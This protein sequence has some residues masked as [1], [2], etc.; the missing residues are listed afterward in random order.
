VSD[1]VQCAA[2]FTD[3]GV[4]VFQDLVFTTSKVVIFDDFSKRSDEIL[5]RC[6]G[7]GFAVFHAPSGGCRSCASCVEVQQRRHFQD[8]SG[9][10]FLNIHMT[11]IEGGSLLQW[12]DC[13]V[14]YF[15]FHS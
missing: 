8:S 14:L 3:S 4:F 12:S 7:W 13:A 10:L 1:C 5:E 15:F 9:D 2:M 11:N 6:L